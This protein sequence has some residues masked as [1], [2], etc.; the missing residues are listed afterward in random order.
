MSKQEVFKEQNI[1]SDMEFENLERVEVETI[2]TEKQY[3]CV[4]CRQ[5]SSSSSSRPIGEAVLLQPTTVLATRRREGEYDELPYQQQHDGVD[6]CGKA[7]EKRKMEMLRCFGKISAGRALEVGL[8]CG[9]HIQTCGHFLH[10]DCHQSYFKSLQDEQIRTYIFEQPQFDI[11]KG[12]FNCPF[13]RR[14]C[15]GV[16]PILPDSIRKR[17]NK[18]ISKCN[19]DSLLEITNSLRKSSETVSC[20]ILTNFCIDAK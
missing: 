11:T 14:P 2:S 20:K 18:K 1:T 7:M 13:C 6:T 9:I 4:I 10:I 3:E 8:D 19:D 12:F 17:P 15:N 16:L 5:M